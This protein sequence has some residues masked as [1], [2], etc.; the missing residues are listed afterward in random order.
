MTTH[1]SSQRGLFL[2]LAAMLALAAALVA[3]SLDIASA[4]ADSTGSGSTA[5][6]TTFT[7]TD[8]HWGEAY[9]DWLS[10][11]C[12]V[13]GYRDDAG[14]LT[15]AFKPNQTIT[16][17]EFTKMVIGCKYPST[18]S[19]SMTGSGST[20]SGSTGS[21]STA[22]GTL[23]FPDVPADHWA[24]WSIEKAKQLGIV[25]GYVDGTFKP[26]QRITRGEIVAIVVRS[27]FP[28]VNMDSTDTPFDDVS[29]DAWYAKYVAF[30]ATRNI[31]SGYKHANGNLTGE[32]GPED[33]ATRAESA[34][35]I[36]NALNA[37]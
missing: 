8:G 31:I 33:P 5:S 25:T 14:R 10:A 18:G 11:H 2:A 34:K 22:S 27:E 13:S 12:G 29:E 36:S 24:A 1:H 15:G 20:G 28:G 4:S 19:G 23:V 9:I 17:A 32:F 37:N 16:R 35:M 30:A 26:N 6:G 3:S 7:D 21:G